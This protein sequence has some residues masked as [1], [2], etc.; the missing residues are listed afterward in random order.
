MRGYG[1]Y[2]D[3]VAILCRLAVDNVGP[4]DYI[5]F[6]GKA[7]KLE[8]KMR[9]KFNRVIAP[10]SEYARTHNIDRIPAELLEP[11][12][13]Y[14]YKL[15]YAEQDNRVQLLI[16]LMVVE[17]LGMR[18]I[19]QVQDSISSI[20][21]A[22]IVL[23]GN[24]NI[25]GIEILHRIVMRTSRKSFEKSHA[26][27]QNDVLKYL[28]A[29]DVSKL[30]GFGIRLRHHV[31]KPLW[32]IYE[33]RIRIGVCPLW[34]KT[35]YNCQEKCDDYKEL[36][37]SY[38][39]DEAVDN[40]DI[41]DA[42]L[43]AAE[44]DVD[45]LLFPEMSGNTDMVSAIQKEIAND[46]SRKLPKVTVLPSIWIN[47]TNY[48]VIMDDRG[49]V[50]CEQHKRVAYQRPDGYYEHLADNN[51]RNMRHVLHIDRIGRILVFICRDFLENTLVNAVVE[52][53]RPTVVLVPSY[54]TGDYDFSLAKG[55]VSAWDCGTTWV[56]ARCA[57]PQKTMAFFC[58]EA[59][60]LP[61]DED[62]FVELNSK[63]QTNKFASF[64]SVKGNEWIIIWY[65]DFVIDQD[66]DSTNGD[67]M[68]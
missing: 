49:N 41:M 50:V 33:N 8:S 52:S 48:S 20:Y 3:L 43:R 26:L 62:K 24:S 55:L 53:I 67:N 66:D 51:N 40:R 27:N 11:I 1:N 30:E 17:Q 35:V 13:E 34:K 54:S 46:K 21:D 31:V 32:P 64:K 14:A 23:N 9:S 60:T 7:P 42:I 37:I 10:V 45:I 44:A 4:D 12:I 63:S 57:A 68:K 19:M 29:V 5:K 22:D 2:F 39:G 65:S 61:K 6:N 25:C 56:N 38:N 58:H 47:G 36:D 28:M 18:F 59:H 16:L 15:N